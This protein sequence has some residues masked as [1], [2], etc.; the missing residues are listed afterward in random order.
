M[1]YTE[2]FCDPVNGN[3]MNG[4]APIGGSY[5][6]VTTNGAFT[7]GGGAGGND[8]FV[9]SSG[10]P[11]ASVNVGDFAA[12]FPD[13]ST[14]PGY[15]GRVTAVNSSTSIDLSGTAKTG[16]RPTTAASGMTCRVG[17]PWKGPN[18][19]DTWPVGSV[20]IALTNSSGYLPRIN[21]LNSGTYNTTV[22]IT[23]TSN[24]GITYQGCTATP[25]DGGRATIDAGG[26]NVIVW[27]QQVSQC[28]V[29][30]LIFTNNGT[31]TSAGFN[32]NAA[33]NTVL[34]CVAHNIRGTGFTSSAATGTLF[35]ECEAYDCNKSNTAN[36]GGFVLNSATAIRCISHDNTTGSNCHGFVV[37]TG[38]PAV[39]H[40]IA[41]TN[42]GD[43]LKYTAS[44]TECGVFNSDFY[45]NS[46]AGINASVTNE[47]LYVESCNFIKN[48][49]WGVL[50][51]ASQ[52]RPI[53]V[54]NCGFGAG[55]QAN[56]SGTTTGLTTNEIA[57]VIYA[58][59]LAPWVDPANGDF[60]VSLA[61]AKGT[62]RGA[63]TETAASYAGTIA[64]PD[65]GAAQ[66]REVSGA[67]AART[68]IT[69]PGVLCG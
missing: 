40:C 13:G 7:Q 26:S 57:S 52:T 62:G 19:A 18:G 46:G 1:S 2:F 20:N 68:R 67:A 30:D 49:T 27:S 29:A 51:S 11:F 22:Q 5:P 10:T 38:M 50:G 37:S 63:F 12:V 9:A 56:G 60:R 39:F 23:V 24:S 45:N 69:T 15:V 8:L 34:R 36:L 17:G 61:A 28:A 16:T 33:G 32:V 35:V 54:V 59:D 47:G 41:D 64:Y 3:K 66:H 14:T 58:A 44:S 43:G 48:G 53:L 31:G 6:F 25:G 21:F 65:I 4:G 42:A 55:T